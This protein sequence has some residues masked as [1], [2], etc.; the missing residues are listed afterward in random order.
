M[1]ANG[2][3]LSSTQTR[4][5]ASLGDLVSSMQTQL[6][7]L[8]Q[9]K[10]TRLMKRMDVGVL[11]DGYRRNTTLG[12]KTSGSSG[13]DSPTEAA[14]L[15]RMNLDKHDKPLPPKR[16]DVGMSYARIEICLKRAEKYV[17]EANNT[18]KV[19]NQKIEESKGREVST[20]C[21]I[22]KELPIQKSGWCEPCWNEWDLYGRPDRHLWELWKLQVRS[23]TR[24][25]L[26]DDGSGIEKYGPDK[27]LL[28]AECP[29]PTR[30]CQAGPHVGKS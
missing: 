18:L 10:L 4:R 6:K 8:S 29:V 5:L 1:A 17:T 28:V 3:K 9:E 27:E 12:D 19:I 11:A 25:I 21:P 16:D 23:T 30:A 26:P 15:A 2:K 20:E 7:G 24:A 13:S 22:C 14:A